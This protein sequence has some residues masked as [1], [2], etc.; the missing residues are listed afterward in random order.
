MKIMDKPTDTLAKQIAD[1]LV[2]KGLITEAAGKKA[3]TSIGA[4]KMSG[5]DWRLSIE[6][7]TQKKK[8]DS[9]S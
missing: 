6:L 1:R 9:E 4:G 5:E 3:Q 7:A 2:K 8:E